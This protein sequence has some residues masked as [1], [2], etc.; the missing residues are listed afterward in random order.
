MMKCVFVNNT[1]SK[2]KLFSITYNFWDD[3]NKSYCTEAIDGT[4]NNQLTFLD[5]TTSELGG[6]LTNYQKL[7]PQDVYYTHSFVNIASFCVKKIIYNTK[8]IYN[9]CVFMYNNRYA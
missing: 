6:E 1:I 9:Y 3:I 7:T 5:N 2:L 8:S 4:K